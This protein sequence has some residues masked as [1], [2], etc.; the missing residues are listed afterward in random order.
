M[1][2]VA[3]GTV[4]VYLVRQHADGLQVLLLHRAPG[5][6]CAGAWEAIHGRIEAGE[7]PE[8]TAMRETAEET[9][10]AVQRLYNVRCH[11]FYLPHLARVNVAV[12]FAAF[13]DA[14]AEY[15]LSGE[16]D[17]AEWRDLASAADR[18][19]WPRARDVLRDIAQLY[20]TGDA[21]PLED[22]LRVR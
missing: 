6:R 7:R 22:V 16:H 11:A 13:V 1:T 15:R 14:S 8:D 18:Y 3:V 17:A 4:D 20:S 9:G 5:V 21:G 19:S 2:Q 10:L 12:V